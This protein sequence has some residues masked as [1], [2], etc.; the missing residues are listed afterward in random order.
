MWMKKQKEKSVSITSIS[1]K[2]ESDGYLNGI[3]I[4]PKTITNE[5]V[6]VILHG[7]R[8]NSKRMIYLAK[9]FVEYKIPTILMDLR[10]HGKSDGDNTDIEKMQNDL[11]VITKHI[12]SQDY[13]KK[14]IILVGVSLGGLIALT[15]GMNNPEIT[16][17][18][19]LAVISSPS[20]FVE[21]LSRLRT[22][23]WKLR[24]RLGGLNLF[25][26][27]ENPKFAPASHVR[28]SDLKKIF[29]LHCKNDHLV[30]VRNF[31][32]NIEAFNIKKDNFHLFKTGGH[33][34]LFQK[35]KVKK[36]IQ[37]WITQELS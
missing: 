36:I 16:H 10:G 27:Q 25:E 8:S 30:D 13:Y 37:N 7:Y 21:G 15:A 1:L 34:F 24:I 23:T 11:G 26:K 3:E 28:Q 29:L 4:I 22:W 12:H 2:L 14:S 17:I 31:W 20:D 33:N 19:G 32:K 35:R 6:A 5:H 9:I 18:I